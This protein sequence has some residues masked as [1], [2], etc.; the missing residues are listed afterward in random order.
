MLLKIDLRV[1]FIALDMIEFE[2]IEFNVSF[3]F[4]KNVIFCCGVYLFE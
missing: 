2:L 4:H 1:K 3:S